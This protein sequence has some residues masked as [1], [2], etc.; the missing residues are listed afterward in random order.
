M[1]SLGSS[2][3]KIYGVRIRI[4]KFRISLFTSKSDFLPCGSYVLGVFA[5]AV[6][7]TELVANASRSTSSTE[8]VSSTDAPISVGLQLVWLSLV[9]GLLVESECERCEIWMQPSAFLEEAAR[10]TRADSSYR[11]VQNQVDDSSWVEINLQTLSGVRRTINV[12]HGV[13]VIDDLRRRIAWALGVSPRLQGLLHDSTLLQGSERLR[14]FV[15]DGAVTLTVV[16]IATRDRDAHDALE[17]ISDVRASMR[18]ETQDA[19]GGAEISTGESSSNG[20]HCASLWA[21]SQALEVIRVNRGDSLAAVMQKGGEK[22]AFK[23]LVCRLRET[24]VMRGLCVH[25]GPVATGEEEAFREILDVGSNR[26]FGRDDELRSQLLNAY[27]HVKD[28]WYL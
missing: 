17:R 9:G 23:A 14:D 1:I 11:Q 21:A 5:A 7:M 16:I 24:V 8:A 2:L 19:L 15:S 6:I 13:E 10:S 22:T 4:H 3:F 26:L 28:K 27:H 25:G 12:D 18:G 20:R